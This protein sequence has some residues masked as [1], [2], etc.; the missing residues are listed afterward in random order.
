MIPIPAFAYKWIAIGAVILALGAAVWVQ[1]E[2]LDTVK[3]EYADFVA[4]V[5]ALGEAQEA[6]TKLKDAEN[7]TRMEKA[8]AENARTRRALATALNGL[9]HASSSGG[10]LSA[11]APTAASPARTCFDPAKL[12]SALRKLD[13]GVLGI[14]EIGSGAVIDLDSAKIWAQQAVGQR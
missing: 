11:P 6:A 9:R 8:N 3:K 1:T 12:D 4:K 7:Q 13:A 14:V 2:R 10:G 5:K